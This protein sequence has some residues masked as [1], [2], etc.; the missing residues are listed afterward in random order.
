MS[1]SQRRRVDAPDAYDG[2]TAE[3]IEKLK[4]TNSAGPP[5]T[6]SQRDAISALFSNLS[7]GDDAA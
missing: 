5:L 4:H 3:Q 1:P 7:G 2:L 6:Q